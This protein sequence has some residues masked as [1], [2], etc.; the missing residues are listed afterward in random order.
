MIV[1]LSLA[2]LATAGPAKDALHEAGDHA[3]EAYRNGDTAELKK[4]AESSVPVD[5][6]LVADG[7][8]ARGAIELSV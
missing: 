1:L 2:A 5:P 3:L 7:L 8:W 4:L 6:W